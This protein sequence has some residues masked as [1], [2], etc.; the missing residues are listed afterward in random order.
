VTAGRNRLPAR[1]HH[2][3][4]GLANIGLGVRFRYDGKMADTVG[5]YYCAGN[6]HVH[7][8]AV[9]PGIAQ[10]HVDQQEE[11]HRSGER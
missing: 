2:I 4:I 7:H 8:V 10:V 6:I 3:D 5:H 9:L 1:R 11:R